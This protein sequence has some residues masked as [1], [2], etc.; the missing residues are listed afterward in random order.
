MDHVITIAISLAGPV[1]L[2]IMGF[3]LRL[4][5][6]INLHEKMLE[7][8]DRRIRDVVSKVNKLDDKTYSIVKNIP[9]Q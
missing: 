5:S 7:A 1:I 8:H 9:R 6:K 2:A 4:Y 3:M